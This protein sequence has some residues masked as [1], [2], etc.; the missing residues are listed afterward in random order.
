M[1][2]LVVGNGGRE[3]AIAHTL[4]QQG[5]TLF[6]L[7][8]NG[9]T[10]TLCDNLSSQWDR[11]DPNDH[12]T[13]AL[14]AEKEKMDLTVVGPQLPLAHG[15]ADYFLSHGLAIF[16]PTKRAVQLE[17]S[18]VFAKEFLSKYRIP[19]ADFALC[20]NL[21]EARRAI[22]ARFEA[23]GGVVVKHDERANEKGVKIC[24]TQE[25]A[26]K[27]AQE[28]FGINPYG[29][30]GNLGLI[31]RPLQGKELSLTCLVD[32]HKIEPLLP[33]QSYKR[34]QEG[35]LGP[36]TEGVGAICPVPFVTKELMEKIN[37]SILNPIL[38][39]LKEEGT[40]YRGAL[41]IDL[42]I[43][44]EGPKVL[45]FK[46]HFSDPETQCLLPLL[47]ADLAKILLECSL[48]ALQTKIAWK[49]EASCTVVMTAEGYPLRPDIGHE[50]AGLEALT[51]TPNTLC[52]HAATKWNGKHFVT[53]GGRVLSITGLGKTVAGASKRAY[54]GV[55]KIRYQAMAYRKDIACEKITVELRDH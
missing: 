14:F 33:V 12:K 7:P 42:M 37:N 16:G 34:L 10:L 17:T 21:R 26:E 40:T 22:E 2:I 19:T 13:L 28:L 50:I 35:N 48:G 54:A 20:R 29:L 25:E 39:G 52:F 3:H 44:E 9:G 32:G 23:W 4:K 5:H 55:E 11:I 1:R 27:A 41:H 47:N 38:E 36:S 46:T 49:E 6:C 45:E 18:Q 43:T 8:G 15:I 51:K 31:E 30:A 53:D 24:K